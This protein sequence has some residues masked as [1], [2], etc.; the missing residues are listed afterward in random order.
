MTDHIVGEY[1]YNTGPNKEL[2]CRI[3]L[4]KKKDS[5]KSIKGKTN[6][7]EKWPSNECFPEREING[8]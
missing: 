7:I 6:T 3:Y 1:I 4:K 2:V 5:Y 8:K